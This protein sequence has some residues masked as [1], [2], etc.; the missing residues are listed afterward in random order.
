MQPTYL[1]WLG[2]FD[3]IAKSDLFVFLDSVQF[4]R[5]SW[6]QRNKIKTRTGE[7]TLT[8]PIKSKG[9]RD[10]LISQT[11][12]DYSQQYPRNHLGSIR[13]NYSK[14]KNFDHLFPALCCEY[15]KKQRLLADLNINLINVM[16]ENI[17]I[18]F[19][20]IRSSQIPHSGRKSG[21]LV[22]ICQYLGASEYL[23][24]I[25][26]RQYIEREGLFRESNIAVTYQ[27]F[28]HPIYQQ[29]FGSFISHLSVI[30][31]LMNEGSDALKTLRVNTDTE[32]G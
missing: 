16:A 18:N 1:P 8:V 19:E 7:M 12:I 13:S 25:G 2:Y 3:L 28:P 32:A 15:E 4:D 10:Q 23:A 14:S 29:L 31:F 20:C 6:Q 26:S 30:D 17:G 22:S 24:P 5:R 11:E 21:V 27:E 9:K